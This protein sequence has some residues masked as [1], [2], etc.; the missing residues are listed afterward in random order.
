[1]ENKLPMQRRLK[2]TMFVLISQG[3]LA[4]L[5]VAWVIHML[6]IAVNGSVYF[7]EDNPL[8]LWTEIGISITIVIFAIV[9]FIS[10]YQRL[11]ERRKTDKTRE[12]IAMTWR[13]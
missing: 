3:L 12:D 11:G 8:I 6:L 5:A 7:V 1:M 13:K 10:Q 9:I 4:A 2:S